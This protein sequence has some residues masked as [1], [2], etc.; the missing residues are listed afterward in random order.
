MRIATA[1]SPIPVTVGTL[2]N[3]RLERGDHTTG[4]VWGMR[5]GIPRTGIILIF[6]V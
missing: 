1:R 5:G 4:G 2:E 6:R 3:F